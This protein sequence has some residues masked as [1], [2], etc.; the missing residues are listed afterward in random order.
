MKTIRSRVSKLADTENEVPGGTTLMEIPVTAG[1]GE[2]KAAAS[3]T[4][5][6]VPDSKPIETKPAEAQE[7][8]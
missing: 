7:E 3:S 2:H 5:E 4:A 8:A 6:T 1:S